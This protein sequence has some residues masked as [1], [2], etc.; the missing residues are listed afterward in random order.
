MTDDRAAPAPTAFE[1]LPVWMRGAAIIG[2][3][4]V[5]AFFLVWV[6]AQSVPKIQAEIES[7]RLEAEKTR[8]VLQMQATQ[9]EQVYR[10]LQRI[11]A[12]AAKSDDERS[13]CFDR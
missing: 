1:G 12:N 10:I 3:P 7:F 4:G 9:T 11:C 5:I 2:I 6:F 8:G 13:R